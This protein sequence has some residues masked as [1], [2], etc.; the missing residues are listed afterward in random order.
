MSEEGRTGAR[1]LVDALAIHDVDT[2]FGVPGESYLAVLDALYDT[3][4]I[5]FVTC[6]QE[7][8]AAMMADAYG[9]LAGRPGICMVS[10]GPGATNASAG[11]HVAY[12]DSTPLILFIGQVARGMVEREAFQEIDYRRMYGEMAKWVAQIDDPARVPEFVSRAFHT[13]TS[14]RPGPVVLALP[15]D[16]LEE[17]ATVADTDPYKTAL[18]HPGAEEM[19]EL[20]EGLAVAKRPLMMLGGGGWDERASTRIQAF[21]EA[22]DLPTCVS[23][24]SQSVFDNTHKNYVG[25]AGVGIDPKLATR[26]EEADLLVVVGA[27]LGEA[28]TS[29]YTLVDVP[30]PRQGLVHVHP[31]P[32]EL[33]RVYQPD[34]AINAAVGPFAAALD[35]LRRIDGSRW[36]D[37]TAA[38]REDY[39]AF[40][41]PTETPGELQLSRIVRWLSDS[42]PDNAIVTNG[43][44]NYA[45]FVNRFY[46][47][48]GYRTQLAPTSGSMGYGLP[49][50][51]A[52]K[53]RHPER[54]VVAFAGDGC[55]QMTMQ[56][57]GTAVQYGAPII[58]LVANN[59]SHGSIRMH[60]ERRYPTRVSGTDLVNPDFAA[61]ARTYGAY[62]GVVRRTDDFADVF[63]RALKAEM[64][65]LIELRVDLEAITPGASLGEIRAEAMARQAP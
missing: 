22:S 40:S 38:A 19:A 57:L 23:F 59:A 7:G 63:Q 30:S 51:I 46:R 48:R 47:Y 18:T 21:A 61:L 53:L 60:Q 42:L 34:L 1:I 12:Q 33:G 52:A 43:A 37:W 10:R 25:H 5:R 64:P 39:L 26:I 49:A 24:R 32:E 45:A 17:T 41:E 62:G 6:R 8:G 11:V 9:K 2:V 16:M 4:Q 15:E 50:A 55:F 28:T 14:G 31:D 29:G 20:R 36:R 54:T 44:G 3:P 65:S 35:G 27:R 56:E 58:V 13:A